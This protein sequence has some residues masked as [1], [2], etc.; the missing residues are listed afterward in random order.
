M[1]ELDLDLVIVGRHYPKTK[2][3]A[4]HLL[5]LSYA[6]I[7][8]K[9]DAKKGRLRFIEASEDVGQSACIVKE[10]VFPYIKRGWSFRIYAT[11]IIQLESVSE[12]PLT[13]LSGSKKE[14]EKRSIQEEEFFSIQEAADKLRVNYATIRKLIKTGEL[15]AAKVGGVWRVTGTG[16][17]NLLNQKE[18]EE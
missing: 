13:F 15:E 10:A 6:D 4:L 16:I 12:L 9:L 1:R 11:K 7:H 5:G 3:E 2:A 8:K 14:P 18:E 17:I